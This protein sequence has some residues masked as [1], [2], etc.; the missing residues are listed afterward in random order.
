MSESKDKLIVLIVDDD[1][2][3]LEQ[4]KIMLSAQGYEVLDAENRSEAE[5]I[6]EHTK[7]DI[8]ILDLMMEEVDDGFVLS[9]HLKKKYPD[10]PVIIIS[11]VTS[12]T[13]IDFDERASEGQWIKAD[14]MLSK[15]IRFE[16]LKRE[17]E[18]LTR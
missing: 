1:D 18:R 5:E 7:P 13:G 10:V 9:Y 11:G 2:D 6:L 14:T 12:E 3:F 8:A 16:Q 17:I 4:Q 15:P